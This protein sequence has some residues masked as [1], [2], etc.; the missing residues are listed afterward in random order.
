MNDDEIRSL[1]DRDI[2][3]PGPG[4]WEGIDHALA[5]AAAETAPTLIDGPPSS[6]VEPSPAPDRYRDRRRARPL[7]T[8]V[9]VAAA[10]VIGLL[11]LPRLRSS[12]DTGGGSVSSEPAD[13]GVDQ[14]PEPMGDRSD[15]ADPSDGQ[16]NTS[17]TWTSTTGCGQQASP[18]EE[19]VF[20]G[21]EVSGSVAGTVGPGTD[22]YVFE[23][24]GQQRAVVEFSSGAG[25]V[26]FDLIDP[27]GEMLVESGERVDLVLP[28]S[29]DYRLCLYATAADVR[30]Q[31]T[32]TIT[33]PPTDGSSASAGLSWAVVGGE[34]VIPDGGQ[35]R[36]ISV[37]RLEFSGLDEL[38]PAGLNDAIDDLI[39]SER[40]AWLAQLDEHGETTSRPQSLDLTSELT[41]AGDGLVSVRVDV[42]TDW[43]V[44]AYPVWWSRA[45]VYDLDRGS[46]IT[47]D[48]LLIDDGRDGLY[49]WI[50]AAVAADYDVDPELLQPASLDE[51]SFALRPEG[52]EVVTGRGVFLAGPY[53][54]SVSVLSW[55]D[56]DGLIDPA[57]EARARAGVGESTQ[58]P[59]I[60]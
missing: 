6:S 46:V 9:A 45:L 55:D 30:Y 15:A 37:E 29:G 48:D 35:G 27:V 23:A 24:R 39:S 51:A 38:G 50:V 36:V 16:T 41:L 1:F 7:I 8:A 3:P 2:M 40:A 28:R 33:G 22:R 4:Y 12:D 21:G 42:Y 10:V 56:L 47:I 58:E 5:T 26:R 32:L 44:S 49:E 31:L 25:A 54:G 19:I 53:P 43:S 57:V 59:G 17:A 34:E 18:V 14:P 11:A 52:L 60:D 13:S 20:A